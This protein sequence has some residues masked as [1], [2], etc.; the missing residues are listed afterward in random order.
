MV[1]SIYP[2]TLSLGLTGSVTAAA[3]L[4]AGT[5][6]TDGES[7]TL[8][9]GTSGATGSTAT[10]TAVSGPIT[11]YTITGTL[12][13]A[14]VSAGGSGYVDGES[15]TLTGVTSG[16]TNAT[17]TVTG[18]GAITAIN[19]VSGGTGY[20]EGETLNVIS[21][22]SGTGGTGT[23]TITSGTKY[24]NGETLTVVGGTGSNATAT[25]VTAT[26]SASSDI[27]SSDLTITT[28]QLRPGGGGTVRLLFG[29]SFGTT[30]ATISVFNNGL[31]KG[32]L[33][34]DNSTNLITN[35]Y[36]RFDVDVEA[37]D[38]INLQSSQTID[39]ILFLRAHLV[40]V[41]A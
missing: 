12:I 29:F 28:D 4:V 33:N 21:A 36:Y 15:V 18:T 41:G 24:I 38:N 37:G 3:V 20:I 19:I 11:A 1:S 9:G 32:N 6:Y 27:L 34:A 23:A 39:G 8:T 31:F 22:L 40:L 10:V 26:L 35:G 13:S 7:V 17:A 5:G 30:P 2:L 16:A 25:A 14:A